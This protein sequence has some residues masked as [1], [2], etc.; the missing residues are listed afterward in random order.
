MPSTTTTHRRFCALFAFRF[1]RR[2]HLGI[3][4]ERYRP[5]RFAGLPQHPT[6]A[7]LRFLPFLVR[8][9]VRSFAARLAP[10]TACHQP[11]SRRPRSQTP[12]GSSC[13]SP[14]RSARSL[15]ARSESLECSC[16]PCNTC[17]YPNTQRTK[18]LQ[19]S[20]SVG[21]PFSAVPRLEFS[22]GA[23]RKRCSPVAQT[24]PKTTA[25]KSGKAIFLAALEVVFGRDLDTLFS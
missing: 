23:C 3:A 16:W 13:T 8:S 22:S 10:L 15:T 2:R 9:P 4:G 17:Y 12:A 25:R 5:V 6:Q 20:G 14:L 18:P 24:R 1:A 19:I 7:V 11:T 21:S